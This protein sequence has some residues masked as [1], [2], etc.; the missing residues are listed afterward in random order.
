MALRKL[1]HEAAAVADFVT[2]AQQ[3][4]ESSALHNINLFPSDIEWLMN[5]SRPLRARN[6]FGR[7]Q[8]KSQCGCC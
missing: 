2:P 1:A 4:K 5:A 7:E 6:A 8:G 3:A